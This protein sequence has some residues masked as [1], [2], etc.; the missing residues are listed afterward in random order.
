MKQFLMLCDE[1]G[2]AILEKVFHEKS[3]Q[4]LE[5]QGMQAG[6]TAFNILVTPTLT[7]ASMQ[8]TMDAA[9]ASAPEPGIAN[10]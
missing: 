5:V 8:P 9:P 4:F 10:E 1:N 2:K 7:P 3:V 6:Q